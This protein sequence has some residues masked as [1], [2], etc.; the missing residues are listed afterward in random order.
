VRLLFVE[1]EADISR[2]ISYVLN[3]QG[4]NVDTAFDVAAAEEKLA[5]GGFDIIL[6]DLMLPGED[7]Y[8]FC[9]RLKQMPHTRAIPVII[10]SARVMPNEI[11]KGLECG[12]QGYITKP[13]DPNT[14]GS[15]IRKIY[16]ESMAQGKAA[17]ETP[18]SRE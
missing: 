18:P 10:I 5:A 2:L 3:T 11:K 8:S 1:N 12:A 13:Y 9:R 14:L 17:A 16:E 6:L 4:F 15:Q 7:G